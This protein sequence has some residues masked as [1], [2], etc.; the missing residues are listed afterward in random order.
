MTMDP[1]QPVFGRTLTVRYA[2]GV[3]PRTGDLIQARAPSGF[4]Y[5]CNLK[6]GVS[7]ECSVAM[8]SRESSGAWTLAWSWT[9]NDSRSNP[10]GSNLTFVAA[11][12][13]NRP[14]C[15]LPFTMP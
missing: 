13:G 1:A 4:T 5:D 11:T 6:P 10:C 15:D 12:G 3:D 7:G 2:G 14:E 8:P 9:G